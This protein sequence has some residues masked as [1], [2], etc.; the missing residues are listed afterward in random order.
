MTCKTKKTGTHEVGPKG[1]RWLTK[2]VHSHLFV[3]SQLN[4]II[5]MLSQSMLIVIKWEHNVS[6]GTFSGE[7]GYMHY[8]HLSPVHRN[9]N[10]SWDHRLLYL[11]EWKLHRNIKLQYH[12]WLWHPYV[13][14]YGHYDSVAIGKACSW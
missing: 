11:T 4:L 13:A 10:R 6:R 12:K 14:S 1:M 9:S 7:G 8:G 5:L 2:A 3:L